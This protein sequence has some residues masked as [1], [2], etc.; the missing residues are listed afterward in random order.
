MSRHGIP[1]HLLSQDVPI[2]RS[3]IKRPNVHQITSLQRA[4]GLTDE[5]YRP[6]SITLRNLLHE[7]CDTTKSYVWQDPEALDKFRQ[8]A[9]EVC[10]ILERYEDRWPLKIFA[11]L[12]LK[13]LAFEH[14]RKQ[15]DATPCLSSSVDQHS[16]RQDKENR[17]P[18]SEGCGKP[19][20]KK[21]ACTGPERRSF[22]IRE[23]WGNF[24]VIDFQKGRPREIKNTSQQS[25]QRSVSVVSY[26]APLSQS[27]PSHSLSSSGG[28]QMQRTGGSSSGTNSSSSAEGDMSELHQ[29]GSVSSHNAPFPGAVSSVPVTREDS[30]NVRPSLSHTASPSG[31]VLDFLTSLTPNLEV[32]LPDFIAA[33]VNDASDF[34]GLVKLSEI[35]RNNLFRHDM[36][37]S[38]FQARVL[39]SGLTRLRD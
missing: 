17:A 21:P 34:R 2:Q 26:E 36:N 27:S 22:R 7:H 1:T 6:L 3:A 18:L 24:R 5:W 16:E 10:P 33:G 31:P 11:R 20:P 39:A 14:R 30:D 9:L 38:C 19:G 15:P 13:R 25:S 35:E 4:M 32:L 12:Q 28:L 8:K 29:S 37:L 23:K